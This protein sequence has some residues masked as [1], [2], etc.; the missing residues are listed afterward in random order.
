MELM[1]TLVVQ[2][3]ALD[4]RWELVL[5]FASARSWTG[6]VTIQRVTQQFELFGHYFMA[7]L[8]VLDFV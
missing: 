6:F 1:F 7:I 5:F 4:S 8:E 2:M 3:Q